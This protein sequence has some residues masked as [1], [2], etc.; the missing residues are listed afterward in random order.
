MAKRT[1]KSKTS[2][3]FSQSFPFINCQ[4]I[5]VSF[6]HK[7]FYIHHI[8]F[9]QQ[10]LKQPAIRFKYM[11]QRNLSKVHH[12]YPSLVW[13]SHSYQ[14]ISW[15]EC[16][17]IFT[18][19]GHKQKQKL[20]DFFFKSA[21][22]PS[23]PHLSLKLQHSVITYKSFGSVTGPVFHF[24]GSRARQECLFSFCLSRLQ[25]EKRC[26]SPYRQMKNLLGITPVRISPQPMPRTKLLH[27]HSEHG[28]VF[29]FIRSTFPTAG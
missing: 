21:L 14:S 9:P 3:W 26:W 4:A 7:A 23:D 2:F 16:I 13:L 22:P 5:K 10:H 27:L 18:S 15:N 19:T 8:T 6:W 17:S 25:S 28:Q 1:L 20:I 24:E 11:Y 12:L 29:C